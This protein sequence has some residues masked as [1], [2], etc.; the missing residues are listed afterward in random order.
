MGDCNLKNFSKT[1]REGNYLVNNLNHLSFIYNN[2]NNFFDGNG[3]CTKNKNDF[4]SKIIDNE[5]HSNL[6]NVSYLNTEK[7]NN[8]PSSIDEQE[9]LNHVKPNTALKELNNFF[10]QKRK[11]NSFFN[12]QS[13]HPVNDKL[14][15]LRRIQINF[16]KE[17]AKYSTNFNY[18]E[19]C[20][21]I[22]HQRNHNSHN[23]SNMS[24]LPLSIKYENQ[25][26]SD[27]IFE[28]W[29]NLL[30]GELS[31]PCLPKAEE[32]M[33][34]Q[35]ELNFE[36]R[37]ILLDWLIDV[38][39]HFKCSEETL[40]LSFSIIDRYLA[41]VNISKNR[42]Q[43]M[44]ITAFLIA[45]KYE[46]IYPPFLKDLVNITDKT[47]SAAEILQMEFEIFSLL[48]FDFTYPT[49][50]SFFQMISHQFNFSIVD[51]NYGCYLM[52]IFALHPGFNKY[53]PSIIALAIAYIILKS[54]KYEKYRIIY[55]LVNHG[56][57]ENDLKLCAREVYDF[58][59]IFSTL[60]FRAVINKYSTNKYNFV[61]IKGLNSN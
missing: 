60:K 41:Q 35:K 28:I 4:I 34:A 30:E 57:S 20:N 56:Y 12:L 32:I 33:K 45:C 47:F 44:G 40:F 22:N 9:I 18:Y 15:N 11:E 50:I 25:I 19:E 38:Q 23:E 16:E 5:F 61:A 17:T 21:K 39:I 51:F 36:T 49:C 8:Q 54:K 29:R 27:Y 42:L 3:N 52:E 53:L 31:Q 58:F 6:H 10:K 48:K 7:N 59:E 13:F 26:P 1:F 24:N 55:Q 46:E 43:L 14:N 37:A 2:P